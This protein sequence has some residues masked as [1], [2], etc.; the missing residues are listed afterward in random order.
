MEVDE[1][2]EGEVLGTSLFN[3]SA[4]FYKMCKLKFGKENL[5]KAI[6][7]H[8]KQENFGTLEKHSTLKDKWKL[9]SHPVF[10][11]SSHSYHHFFYPDDSA[12]WILS[13][14]SRIVIIIPFVTI[15][16]WNWYCF[17]KF[18][19]MALYWF[20]WSWYSVERWFNNFDLAVHHCHILVSM[21]P[22]FF[23]VGNDS[24][25]K[26]WLIYHFVLNPS[27]FLSSFW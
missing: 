22:F 26:Y 23:Q 5:E 11:M 4:K 8:E 27:L 12:S 20:S 21:D 24:F 13:E 10:I 2:S 1:L 6:K 9:W 16:Y 14:N 25:D 7:W 19:Q 17:H 18:L 3:H 15:K